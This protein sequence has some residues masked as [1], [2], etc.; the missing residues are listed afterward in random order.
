M[1]ANPIGKRTFEKEPVFD[2]ADKSVHCEESVILRGVE[3]DYLLNFDK[4][5]GIMCKKALQQITVLKRIGKLL[6]LEVRKAVYHAFY[7]VKFQ[8]L[9]VDMA[10]L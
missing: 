6:T 7:H 1:E 5:V 10:L 8:F 2:V 9:S 4:H 3:I